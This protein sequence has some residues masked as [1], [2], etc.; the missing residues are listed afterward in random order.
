M[1]VILKK[2]KTTLHKVAPKAKI[3]LFGSQAR[4]ESHEGSDID[5]MVILKQNSIT[6]QEEKNILSPLYAI[7]FET[8]KIISPIVITEK[9]WEKASRQTTFYHEVMKDGILL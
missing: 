5:L 7:E 3:I 9:E 1:E 4:N 2:I 6:R 8:G